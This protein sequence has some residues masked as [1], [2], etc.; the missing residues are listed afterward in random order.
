MDVIMDDGSAREEREG[1]NCC[2]LIGTPPVM[3]P[4]RYTHAQT[5]HTTTIVGVGFA[6]TTRQ[7]PQSLVMPLLPSYSYHNYHYYYVE[8]RT[9]KH[10]FWGG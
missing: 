7:Q 1:H 2:H 8:V 6:E 10:L 3:Q 9:Y 5:I 4:N